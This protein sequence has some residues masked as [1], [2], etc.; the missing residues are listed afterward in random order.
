MRNMSTSLVVSVAIVLT[1]GGC[2]IPKPPPEQVSG[3]IT[4]LDSD[5]WRAT[6]R[7]NDGSQLV[8]RNTFPRAK[9]FVWRFHEGDCITFM[10]SHGETFVDP[11]DLESIDIQ[12]HDCPT[13]GVT[14]T[15]S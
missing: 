1:T 3:R 2:S 13:P 11:A 10:R 4:S 6:V 9:E 8:L 15:P 12:P 14:D 7:L 5:I